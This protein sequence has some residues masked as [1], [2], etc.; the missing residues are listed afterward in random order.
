MKLTTSEILTILAVME[1]KQKIPRNESH[2]FLNV[3]K[4]DTLVIKLQDE[5]EIKLKEMNK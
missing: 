3:H 4:T 1:D 5:L 2:P